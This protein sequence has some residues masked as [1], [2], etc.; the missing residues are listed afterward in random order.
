MAR[1][2]A[3]LDAAAAQISG[4]THVV[5]ADLTDPAE[6]ARAADEVAAALGP[7]DV[8]VSCAGPLYR[9]FVEDVKP[10]DFDAT[11]RAHVGGALWLTQRVLP[12]MRQRRSG[13]IVFVSSEFGLFGGPSYASY[14]AAKFALV[15]LSEVLY[16]ELAGSGVHACAVCP[17]D[18]RT[19][20]LQDD[21]AWGPT[22]GATFE[23]A[24]TPERV[25]RDRRCR[26]GH[27]AGGDHRSCA[28]AAALRDARR[29]A[30]ADALGGPHRVQA[31]PRLARRSVRAV[32]L[33]PAVPG[34]WSSLADCGWGSAA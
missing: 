25:A 1:D 2:R 9:D 17:G 33:G 28:D 11:W 31:A 22:G 23:K 18:V 20:Q 21:L 13:S 15:G 12:G 34:L 16:H 6:C 8:L 24:M 7:V 4:Q 26:G 32:V 10:G 30:P 27:Q 19:A 3:A 5:V 14:C 29:P